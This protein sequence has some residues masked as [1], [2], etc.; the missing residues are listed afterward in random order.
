MQKENENRVIFLNWQIKSKFTKLTLE[1]K[2]KW[3][4]KARISYWQYQWQ[5]SQNKK[6]LPNRREKIKGLSFKTAKPSTHSI[7]NSWSKFQKQHTGIRFSPILY[8]QHS[9]KSL[10]QAQ[11]KRL[12][13]PWFGIGYPSYQLQL[14]HFYPSS[15]PFGRVEKG[16]VTNG[17]KRLQTSKPRE[18]LAF[19]EIKEGFSSCERQSILCS[20]YEG[21]GWCGKAVVKRFF[22]EVAQGWR[23]LPGRGMAGHPHHH[24]CSISV[25]TTRNFN[26]QGEV[27]MHRKPKW[28]EMR[29]ELKRRN[30]K[31]SKV[32]QF[33]FLRR[34]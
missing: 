3:G 29:N 23:G 19:R 11:K 30:W 6:K 33:I 28:M 13:F 7:S 31:W 9:S 8:L 20:S 22:L 4:R 32:T 15:F 25:F 12:P 16:Q 27:I 21:R 26:E 2:E 10:N 14:H 1:T 18:I 5:I 17:P 24:V 34:T